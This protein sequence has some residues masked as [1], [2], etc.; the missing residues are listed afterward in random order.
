MK[1]THNTVL[2]YMVTGPNAKAQCH[3]QKCYITRESEK[4]NKNSAVFIYTFGE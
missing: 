1:P 4:Q 3:P 2:C